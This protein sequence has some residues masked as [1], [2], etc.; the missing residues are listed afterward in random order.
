MATEQEQASEGETPSP[1]PPGPEITADDLRRMVRVLGLIEIP[2]A[3]MP[4]VL[5]HV[6][7]HRAAMRTFEAAGIEVGD[8]VTA[9]PFRA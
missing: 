9:Q 1:L 7:A 8:V 5:E 3:L 2:E 6:R 4:R